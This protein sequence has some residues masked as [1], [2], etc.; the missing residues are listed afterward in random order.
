MAGSFNMDLES[1]Q[2]LPE[3]GGDG[4]IS[5]SNSSAWNKV[6]FHPFFV[7]RSHPIAGGP[8]SS[9]CCEMTESPARE[10]GETSPTQRGI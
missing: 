2:D 8:A 1:P 7:V 10:T 3:Q 5:A 6:T 9:A 4:S